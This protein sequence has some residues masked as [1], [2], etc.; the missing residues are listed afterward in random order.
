MEQKQSGPAT[1]EVGGEAVR[2]F[3]TDVKILA[4]PPRKITLP[5]GCTCRPG[6]LP[7]STC[8]AWDRVFHATMA[9]RAALQE[10]GQ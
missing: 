2:H 1:R 3:Q 9:V 4:F 8:R 10:A 6:L 7:C 5:S